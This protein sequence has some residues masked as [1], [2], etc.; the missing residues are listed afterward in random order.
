[1]IINVYKES[2]MTSRDVVNILIKHFNTKKIGHTG[3]LDPIATGVLICCLDSSTKLVNIIQS[4]TKEY[5]AEIKLGIK[6]D[7]GD[8]T[9]KVIDTK[10][11]NLNENIIISTLNSFLGDSIQ[12]VPIYSAVKINGKKLYEYAR[13]NET[14][15]L[16]KRAIYISQIE[17]LSYHDDLIKFKVTVSKGTYIRS[18]I[19]DICTKLNTVGTMFSLCRTKQGIFDIETSNK[20]DDILLDNYHTISYDEIFKDYFKVNMTDIE[21]FK[22][23]NGQHMENNYN[24]QEVLF[25][26]QNKY[27]ALYELIDNTLKV[28][29]MFND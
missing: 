23:K 25:M 19:N 10:P 4:I 5:I 17:L 8:I 21:Y 12:E 26:Y 27:I 24:Q 14:V 29:L 20:L 1:M 6:T 2:N 3:T 18:L 7:T 22:V 28:K 9:G 11:Y 16:P 15:E 13:K